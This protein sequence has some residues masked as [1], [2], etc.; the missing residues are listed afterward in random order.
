MIKYL[1]IDFGIKKVG[2][3]WADDELLIAMPKIN[4]IHNNNYY[5][6]FSL[7][8]KEIIMHNYSYI[9]CGSPLK[10]NNFP[11]KMALKIDRFLY[12]LKYFCK[13]LTLFFKKI[14][15]SFSSKEVTKQ[16]SLFHIKKTY[17]D[18]R[19][20]TKILQYFLNTLILKK[21]S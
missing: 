11:T 16:M 14:D 3:S 21:Q 12:E 15:E 2:L 9:I 13:T 6:L 8:K 7:I 18:N 19:V 5:L 4:I 1:G 17:I 20:A 10:Q